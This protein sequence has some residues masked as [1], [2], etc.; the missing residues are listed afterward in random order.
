MK[1]FERSLRKSPDNYELLFLIGEKYLLLEQPKRALEI[2]ELVL[3]LH[4][5]HEKALLMSGILMMLEGTFA[6]AR[7]LLIKSA[8][9]NS[10]NFVPLLALAALEMQDDRL[11]ESRVFA[12][13][14]NECM[15]TAFGHVIIAEIFSSMK[16]PKKASKEF[17]QALK[18]QPGDK[19]ILIRLATL[20]MNMGFTR[21]ARETFS[22][23]SR[24]SPKETI[25]KELADTLT[26]PEMQKLASGRIE[27]SS[28]YM[29]LN[30][31]SELLMSELER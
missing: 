2:W 30:S 31:V 3:E 9:L 27:L 19:H 11:E 29:V 22:R 20:Y 28:S 7:A 8:Q 15:D 5:E 21:R 1:L 4:S 13:R 26:Q 16:Q 10:D 23:I 17:E 18:L 25:F 24:I 12:D 6:G 14:A